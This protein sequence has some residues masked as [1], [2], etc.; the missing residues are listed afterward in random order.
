MHPKNFK[1]P[2]QPTAIEFDPNKWGFMPKYLNYNYFKNYDE[3]HVDVNSITRVNESEKSPVLDN[4]SALKSSVIYDKQKIEVENFQNEVESVNDSVNNRINN[5]VNNIRD[6][7]YLKVKK[8]NCKVE[9]ENSPEDGCVL[10]SENFNSK[11]SR[12]G[13]VT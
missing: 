4:N 7:Q 6:I 11:Y 12:T 1:C 8:T 5:S 10:V 3:Q 9:R 13:V 2:L